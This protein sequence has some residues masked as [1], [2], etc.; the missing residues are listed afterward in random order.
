MLQ[1]INKNLFSQTRRFSSQSN[2]Y[3]INK[4]K[5]TLSKNV[6]KFNQNEG[7]LTEM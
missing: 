5:D 6:A 7:K 1:K 4:F 2:F 3:N